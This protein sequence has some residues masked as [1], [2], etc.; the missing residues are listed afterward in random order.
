MHFC[1]LLVV[2]NE[3]PEAQDIIFEGREMKKVVGV[4]VGHDGEVERRVGLEVCF[5]LFQ[6][7]NVNDLVD[8]LVH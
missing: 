6:R 1:K 8:G 5:D 2:P 7:F 4:L 3:E